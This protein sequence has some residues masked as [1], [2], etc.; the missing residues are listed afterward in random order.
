[1]LPGQICHL[2]KT[3]LSSHSFLR[4]LAGPSKFPDA[5]R[6]QREGLEKMRLHIL[7]NADDMR[8]QRK[9]NGLENRS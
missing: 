3:A 7:A 1:L 6:A 2:T 8:K 9:A 4:V 5:Y